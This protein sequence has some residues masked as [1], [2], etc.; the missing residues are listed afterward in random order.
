MSYSY[1]DGTRKQFQYYKI[2]GE[3]TFSQ[4]SDEALFWQYNPESNSIGIIVKHLWGNMMSRFTDFLTS[5][6]EK[7]WREREAEF[8]A[9]I[10]TR[11]ELLEK[12]EAG[13]KAVFEALESV[14]ENKLDQLVYIRN[15]GHTIVEAFNRQLAHYA[16]H[17]GQI[18]YLGRMVA[19][20]DWTSLSIPRGG[21]AA[22][23]AQKFAE[24]KRK[25]H[26]TD[27]FLGRG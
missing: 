14:D 22:Y 13:W 10:Q 5:D 27:G 8:D 3:K 1:I 17:I 15:V 4:V 9:D 18:V 19:G 7:E 26:F 21:S 2:L 20:P 24:E 11:E 25:G 23:N 6:G 16:Y 12:W